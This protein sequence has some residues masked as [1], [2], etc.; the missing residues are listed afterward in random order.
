MEIIKYDDFKKLDLRVAK[1][2]KAERF[3]ESE[4]LVKLQIDVGELGRRQLVAGIG[5]VY[6]P[7][8]LI[9]K[10]IV[11]VVNLE[12]KK[13]MGIESNGMLLA[14]SDAMGPVLLCPESEV[15]PG[16]TIK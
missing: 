10:Q 15:A 16:T 8:I 13:L 6:E 3:E 1:I 12:S 2:L 9:N 4:K 7:E 5:T 14:A 11:I